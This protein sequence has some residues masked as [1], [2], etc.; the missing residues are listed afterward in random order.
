MGKVVTKDGSIVYN[1]DN[2]NNYNK[3]ILWSV[4][5]T[6]RPGKHSLFQPL[7]QRVDLPMLCQ[8]CYKPIPTLFRKQS[9]V[10]RGI[11]M[12]LINVNWMYNQQR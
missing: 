8:I 7:T 6:G 1:N 9:D 4:S 5:N 10:A 12:L 3:N 2:N 11:T